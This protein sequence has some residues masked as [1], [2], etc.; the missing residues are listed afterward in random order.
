LDEAKKLGCDAVATGHYAQ[1]LKKIR[2]QEVSKTSESKHKQT[3]L[4]NSESSE[5]SIVYSLYQGIDPIK[6]QSYFLS[7]LSQDQLAHA[8]FPLGNMMKSEVR[9]LAN[10][11]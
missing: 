9:E 5:H 3:N 4:N 1:I 6:D 10:H 11:I 8:I 2:S 7:R